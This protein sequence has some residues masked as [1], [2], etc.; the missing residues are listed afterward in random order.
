MIQGPGAVVGREVREQVHH[1][2]LD[3]QSRPPPRLPVTGPEIEPDAERLGGFLSRIEEGDH[4]LGDD[5][6]QTVL[7]PLPQ[8]LALVRPQVPARGHIQPNLAAPNL[9]GEGADV[10]GPAVEGSTGGEIEA[11][12]VPVAG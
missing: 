8:T 7:Q 5:E 10:V 2:G 6:R 1:A 11:C 4:G 12:V 3:G 9:D